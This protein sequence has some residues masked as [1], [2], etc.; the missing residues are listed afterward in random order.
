LNIEEASNVKWRPLK[1]IQMFKLSPIVFSGFIA[2]ACITQGFATHLTDESN[3]RRYN[4]GQLAD[5][6]PFTLIG[7][8]EE[9]GTQIWT[10]EAK[11][12]IEMPTTIEGRRVAKVTFKNTKACANET[13]HQ[14]IEMY[15]E[16]CEELV[17]ILTL[18]FTAA[19][20][21]KD[22]NFRL[23]ET[24][25]DPFV[26]N[27]LT[28][29][30]CL[31]RVVYKDNTEDRSLA[32]ALR[33]VVVEFATNDD[34]VDEA[35]ELALAQSRQDNAYGPDIAQRLAELEFTINKLESKVD[36]LH[37]QSRKP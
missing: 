13:H 30:H 10:R 17:G 5:T 16:P 11:S 7:F 26:I 29:N 15:Y 33:D 18:E 19:D 1:G 3:I 31:P 35:L 32:L 20:Q 28:P 25:P 36:T 21:V 6:H 14:N 9:E 22:L 34:P 37:R 27:I 12:R 24:A 4:L 23:T 2:A 8:W